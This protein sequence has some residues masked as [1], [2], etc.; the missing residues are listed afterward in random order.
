MSMLDARFVFV[1]AVCAV[2]LC[3]IYAID[4]FKGKTQPNRV[5]WFL[6][7][8]APAIAF[9][10]QISK[11]VG[12]QSLLTFGVGFGPL[13]VLLASFRAREAYLKFRRID[14]VCGFLSLLALILW[15]TTGDAN[16]AI[17]FSVL[18]DF[19][20]AVPTLIKAYEAPHTESANAY[21]GGSVGGVVT[22]LTIRH[23]T[24]ADYA[25]PMY[26]ACNMGLISLLVLFPSVR[27]RSVKKSRLVQND[28]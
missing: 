11:G 23:W 18:A 7:M 19:L 22:L 5:T 24:I 21:I 6:W 25:F 8:L 17:L 27:F 12:L 4:T 9:S 3:L 15:A 10:A 20:A 26:L 13:L 14:F 16:V 28:S 2:A 1:G